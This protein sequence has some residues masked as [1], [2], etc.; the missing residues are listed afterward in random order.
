VRQGR[1]ANR[2]IGRAAANIALAGS[3]VFAGGLGVVNWQA[4]DRSD[5]HSG[6]QFVDELFGAL[7]QNAAIL[8]YWDTSTPL[9]YAQLVEH[10]R[11]DVLVVDDTDIVYGGWQSREAR[12]AALVCTR[13]SYILRLE[14]SELE[15][16]R[17]AYLLT[18]VV[19]LPVARG[20]PSMDEYRP[21]Y[22]VDPKSG[23]CP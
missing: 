19:A 17:A 23:A 16:T 3:I 1:A 5:D 8:S 6:Q 11:P 14:E 21:L 22:K 15:P 10:L 9:W 2:P 7:P 4:G 20:G 18:P 12:L 13:P